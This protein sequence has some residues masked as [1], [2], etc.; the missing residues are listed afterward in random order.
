M[1]AIAKTQ[2]GWIIQNP[3]H[4]PEHPDTKH[5]DATTLVTLDSQNATKKGN[6]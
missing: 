4:K 6:C 3:P 1:Q 5:M 2:G